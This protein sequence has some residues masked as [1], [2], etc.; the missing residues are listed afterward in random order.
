MTFEHASNDHVK[1]KVADGVCEIR[2]DDPDRL[3]CFSVELAKDLHEITQ[4]IDDRE[5]VF[6]VVITGE[7][8]AFSSGFDTELILGEGSTDEIFEYARPA[9]NWLINS[10]I[11]V[12][13]GGRNYAVGGGASLLTY[14]PDLSYINADM[15][16]WWP[17]V[18][19]GGLPRQVVSYLYPDIGYKRALEMVLLGED[20][21]MD[22]TEAKHSGLVNDIVE[23][24]TVD[25]K[26][27]QT[28]QSLADL[29]A[30]YG[31]TTDLMDVMHRMRRER[32]G[33]SLNYIDWKRAQE[34]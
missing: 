24:A 27:R 3:N 32:I 12:V 22:A 34:E 6:A 21:K 23:S 25:E 19:Y 28:A 14:V 10:Q 1:R 17:E 15:E 5:D 4:Y 7:G 16:I 20:G 29:E 9:L 33:N 31:H 11:P 18:D 30:E 2:L 8:K 13:A 26:A